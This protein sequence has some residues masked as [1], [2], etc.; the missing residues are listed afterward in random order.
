MSLFR[1]HYPALESD[2]DRTHA[3]P[4]GA[5]ASFA[6]GFSLFGATTAAP[7]P[8]PAAVPLQDVAGAAGD[9][10]DGD[11]QPMKLQ[12]HPAWDTL[13]CYLWLI[14]VP[15][16]MFI[17]ISSL[18]VH[19]YRHLPALPWAAVFG[20]ALVGVHL[21]RKKPAE[22][23]N[24]TPAYW[25]LVGALCLVAVAISTAVGLLD[26]YENVQP[27]AYYAESRH[28]TNVLASEPSGAKAD[29]GMVSFSIDSHVDPTR[30]VGY[31]AGKLY[32]VAPVLGTRPGATVGYWAAGVDCCAPRGQFYCG[33]VWNRQ[34]RAGLVLKDLG[35]F[36]RDA[37]ALPEFQKAAEAA[38]AA[39]DLVLSPTPIFLRWV[40]DPEAVHEAYRHDAVNFLIAA[41]FVHLGWSV[42]AG[43][44]YGVSSW[45]RQRKPMGGS[46]G[47]GTRSASI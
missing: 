10:A 22:L 27:F 38:A 44:F 14:L 23:G 47:W 39:Y 8:A 16:A 20:C 13:V 35:A 17:L 11:T 41:I 3:A 15:W 43:A 9:H 34:A 46:W 31:R 7:A 37:P 2:H 32:C 33:D 25:S 42:L 1:P 24:R 18:F 28:Y 36:A 21:Y 26:F 4:G 45:V 19:Q 12:D 40:A 6:G 29:A 30:A 5:S